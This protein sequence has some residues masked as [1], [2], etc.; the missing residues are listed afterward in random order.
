MM[1]IVLTFDVHKGILSPFLRKITVLIYIR[2]E[3]KP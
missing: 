2:S 1:N 3:D